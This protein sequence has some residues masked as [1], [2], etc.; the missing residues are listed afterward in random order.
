MEEGALSLMEM[1]GVIEFAA[2][3]IQTRSRHERIRLNRACT[4]PEIQIQNSSW[5]MNTLSYHPVSD[6]LSY[7]QYQY[8]QSQYPADSII[9]RTHHPDR[10]I[11]NRAINTLHTFILAGHF[12]GTTKTIFVALLL[13]KLL[14]ISPG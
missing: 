6:N 5:F 13:W 2:L 12:L 4:L 8:R 7:I 11:S 9:S 14:E 3:L 1:W 10:V